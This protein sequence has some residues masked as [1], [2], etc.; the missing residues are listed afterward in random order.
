MGSR[1]TIEGGL[2]EENAQTELTNK[3]KLVS[4]KA[5]RSEAMKKISRSRNER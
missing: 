4:A 5:I 3:R 1:G 2:V